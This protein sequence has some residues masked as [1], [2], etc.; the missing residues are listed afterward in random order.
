MAGSYLA[1]VQCG[2]RCLASTVPWG[3]S[4]QMDEGGLPWAAEQEPG[5]HGTRVGMRLHCW[6]G[7]DD[8]LDMPVL[9]K[10]R[11]CFL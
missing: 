9:L 11:R 3:A 6:S 5:R 7:A 4:R 10:W 1:T 2:D 8:F